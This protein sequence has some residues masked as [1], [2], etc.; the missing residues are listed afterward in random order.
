MTE[1]NYS[2]PKLR[3]PEFSEP[4]NDV[5]LGEIATFA[6]GKGIS[7]G[8]IDPDGDTYCVRYGELYTSY[9][10]II[11]EPISKTSVPRKDLVLSKGGEVIIPASG[12]T[13]EGISTAAV[14]LR[15]D[16]ALGGDLNII[17]SKLNGGFLAPYLSGKKRKALA[18]VALG[19]YVV[20]LYSSQISAL[21]LS[22]PSRLEQDKIATFISIIDNKIRLL[23]SK[24]DTLETY[25]KGCMQGL[26]SGDIRF[27]RDAGGNFPDSKSARLNELL[28]EPKERNKNLEFSKKDVLTVSGKHG[29]VN[30]IG[31]KGRSYAGVSVKDYQV[32]RQGDFVYTK[33]SLK[34]NPYGVIKENK[35]KDGIVS[36]LYAVYRVTK[37]AHADYLDYYFQLDDN[38]NRYLRPIVRRGA[39]ND[40][41]VNNSEVLGGPVHIPHLDEQRKIADFL[42][43]LDTK[44]SLVAE[45]LELACT[46]KKGLLEQMFV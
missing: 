44:L 33:S 6:K 38:L 34:D 24:H 11:D 5:K 43:A 15:K 21:Q 29:F 19:N 13:A 30:Q 46:F 42:S 37:E 31:F 12:E 41:N 18:S 36:P 45:E 9:D 27:K 35:G 8:E 2:A 39:R 10:T 1:Q 20:H 22:V 4:W 14:V 25:R 23:K 7:K 3:F 17:F 32:V 28:F 26:F 16:I 40:L